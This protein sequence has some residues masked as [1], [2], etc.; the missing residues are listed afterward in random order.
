ME[1]IRSPRDVGSGT[2][3]AAGTADSLSHACQSGELLRRPGAPSVD[4]VDGRRATAIA[5]AAT[6]LH[7]LGPVS[8]LAPPDIGPTPRTFPGARRPDRSWWVSS[9]GLRIAAYEWGPSEAPCIVM[10]HG[11]FDFAGTFDGFAPLL[12]DGGYRV[13]SWDARGHGCSEHAALY[14]WA[15][16]LRDAVAVIDSASPD[17]PVVFLGHSKGG[18]LMLDLAHAVPHRLT[19]LVNLDGLPSK[20]NW[21]DLADHERT[22]MLRGEI[23]GWLD[24]RRDVAGKSRK[25]GTI[26][27]LA[28]RRQRMNPRLSIEWLEYLVT[29]GGIED[30]DGWR[31]RI[32][33][34]LRLGGFGPWRPEWSMQ[35]LPGVGVPTLGVLGLEREVMGWGTLPRDVEPNRPPVFAFC[36]LEDTGHFMHIE[37]PRRIA[38]LV[39]DFLADHPSP[40]LRPGSAAPAQPPVP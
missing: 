7:R 9:D 17:V 30:A 37:Q 3:C 35:R 29:I 4:P 31:W 14:S 13:V 15:A 33:P 25:P 27:E 22:K 39:L 36:A 11:G 5:G 10:A 38:D 1:A 32:D 16:D 26:A 12:V 19:H 23:E 2:P 34:T 21:P 28:E 8:D 20:N 40:D 18:G 6:A 24:H